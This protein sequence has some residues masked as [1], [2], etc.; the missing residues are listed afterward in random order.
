MYA[1][2]SPLRRRALPAVLAVAATVSLA[3]SACSSSDPYSSDTSTDA[4]ASTTVVVGSAGFP[5]SEIVAEI[6]AQA[7][8]AGGID[9]S[10]SMSIGQRD[11]YLAALQD[12][13]I[14]LVPEYSGNLLQYYDEASTA[15]TSDEVLEALSKAV[16]DGYEVLDQAPAEDKDSYNVTAEFASEHNLKSLAD[17]AALDVP[18]TIGGNPE[19]AKRPYGP[20]GLTKIYGVPADKITFEPYNDSG[21]PLTVS[22]LNDGKVQVADIFTTS[23]AITDNKFVTLEDPENMILPQNI[24]PL[25]NSEKASDE[26]KKILNE[27]SAKLTTEDLVALNARSE[28]SEKASPSTLAKDWLTEKGLN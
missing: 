1:T 12:G 27:V 10:T 21:G 4:G 9:V 16:P 6:Y 22:A 2:S 8:T 13:S 7:L 20:E 19:L 15:R 28:G 23:P 24:L 11:V 26:V 14:D 25:M 5:E 18:I 3:L 17:L